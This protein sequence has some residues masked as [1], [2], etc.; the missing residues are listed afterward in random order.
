M[1]FV[2]PYFDHDAFMHH[3]M[4]TLYAPGN[5]MSYVKRA[6]LK[7][8]RIAERET[9]QEFEV[10]QMTKISWAISNE[11]LKEC[12]LSSVDMEKTQFNRTEN[13]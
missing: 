1:F 6:I 13:N 11:T 8:E 5:K 7:E 2:F 10:K 9:K 3:T 12:R 4:H